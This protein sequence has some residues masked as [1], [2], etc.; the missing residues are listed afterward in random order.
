MPSVEKTVECDISDFDDYDLIREIKFRG[1]EDEFQSNDLNSFS[2]HDL[3]DEL[4]DR[5]FIV[6][7][8]NG[9]DNELQYLYSTWLTCS[10]ESFEE[11]LKKFFRRNLNVI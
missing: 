1:L 4:E 7:S 11:E 6:L 3:C 9:Y 10:K 2:D 8:E 5:G